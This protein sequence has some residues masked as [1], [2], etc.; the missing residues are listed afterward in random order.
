MQ[1]LDCLAP[2]LLPLI[3]VKL[4]ILLATNKVGGTFQSAMSKKVAK[5]ME[6]K[7]LSLRLIFKVYA[8]IF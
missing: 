1:M 3:K 6:V 7:K 4:L 8:F 2:I 5:V